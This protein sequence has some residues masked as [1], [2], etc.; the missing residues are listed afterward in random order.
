MLFYSSFLGIRNSSS[1]RNRDT[2]QSQVAICYSR[3]QSSIMVSAPH[4]EVT[5]KENPARASLTIIVA[6]QNLVHPQSP[7]RIFILKSYYLSFFLNFYYTEL[8]KAASGSIR[9][10]C[11]PPKEQY[12]TFVLTIHELP[13]LKHAQLTSYN[14]AKPPL[15]KNQCLPFMAF[16]GDSSTTPVSQ[17]G[18]EDLEKQQ[19]FWTSHT[20]HVY[21]NT[22][23][24]T[25]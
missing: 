2:P 6:A 23:Y 16:S 19:T 5:L 7:S 24:H 1:Q 4:V 9:G 8:S 12:N 18:S 25:D 13:K 20:V 21:K 14:T 10:G 3:H 22:T 15:I 17:P 11:A